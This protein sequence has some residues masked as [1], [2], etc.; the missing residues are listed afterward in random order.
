MIPIF[1]DDFVGLTSTWLGRPTFLH[2]AR[3]A[4]FSIFGGLPRFE[5]SE[6]L[7]V[8]DQ[9]GDYTVTILPNICGR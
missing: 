6:P 2:P 9:F 1:N 8:D 3:L 5:C 7:M 4:I